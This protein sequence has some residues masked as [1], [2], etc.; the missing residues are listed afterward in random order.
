LKS[1]L[2]I[3]GFGLGTTL[4]G[5]NMLKIRKATHKD[6]EDITLLW[7]E[8]MDLHESYDNYY[9]RA[10]NGASVFREF[11]DKQISERNSVVLVGITNKIICAYLLAKI[12]NRPA[13]FSEKKYGYISDIAVAKNYR[14]NGIGEKLYNE[15]F[16]WFKKRKIKRIELTVATSN[17]ISIKFWSKLS[18]KPYSERRFIEVDN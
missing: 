6:V 2:L 11:I 18:F 5:V 4:I 14:R 12:N 1:L 13:V 7:C 9:K 15:A 10:K 16:K 17:P 3:L 8:F